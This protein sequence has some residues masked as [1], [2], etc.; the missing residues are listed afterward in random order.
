MTELEKADK[1]NEV[2]QKLRFVTAAIELVLD[3]KDHGHIAYG[4]YL[5]MSDLDAELTA[6]LGE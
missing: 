5:I 3:G 1:I 6:V 2:R 4:G